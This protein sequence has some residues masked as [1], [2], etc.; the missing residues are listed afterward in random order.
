MCTCNKKNL[1]HDALQPQ[2]QEPKDKMTDEQ[3][4]REDN[5][6]QVD[7]YIGGATEGHGHRRVG[8][9]PRKLLAL[10]AWEGM[11]AAIAGL[12]PVTFWRITKSIGA[13]HRPRH[14][15]GLRGGGSPRRQVT[16][17]DH[18]HT[19]IQEDETQLNERHQQTI[20][21]AE[22]TRTQGGSCALML[23]FRGGFECRRIKPLQRLHPHVQ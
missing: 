8:T 11:L 19:H 7:A 10:L 16:R 3:R 14:I 20:F 18:E 23:W 6:E 9:R 2:S 5:K 4:Q 12:G 15:F 21:D 1:G 22:G 13:A 17:L